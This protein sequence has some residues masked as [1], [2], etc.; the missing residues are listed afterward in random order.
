MPVRPSYVELRIHG[1]SGTTPEDML[2]TTQVEDVAGDELVRFVRAAEPTAGELPGDGV[3]EAVSWGRLTSGLAA[4]AAWVVM[5]PFALVNL[6]MWT[7]RSFTETSSRPRAARVRAAASRGCVRL[8]G[9]TVTVVVTLAA[10]LLA[11]D[12]VGWQCGRVACAVVSDRLAFAEAWSRGARVAVASAVPVVVLAAIAWLSHRVS[13]RY[14]AA[15]PSDLTE[16]GAASGTRRTAGAGAASGTGAQPE[17]TQ[18]LVEQQPNLFSPLMWHAEPMVQRLRCVHLSVG[19]ASVGVLLVWA[20][21]E[22]VGAAVLRGGVD[23]ALWW[24]ATAC[25]ALVIVA[26]GLLVALPTG[27]VAWTERPLQ[28]QGAVATALQLL[29]LAGVGLAAASFARTVDGLAEDVTGPIPGLGGVLAVVVW[30]Q[31][32]VL[33]ALG[34]VQLSWSRIDHAVDR[35]A[36]WVLDRLVPRPVRRLLTARSTVR[37][38]V[39]TAR[40]LRALSRDRARTRSADEAEPQRGRA[41]AR[42]DSDDPQRGRGAPLPGRDAARS[43]GPRRTL[44]ARLRDGVAG[45]KAR[46]QRRAER[47]AAPPT[48]RP[49]SQLPAFL[50]LAPWVVAASGVLLAYVYAAGLTLRIGALLTPTDPDEGALAVPALLTWASGGFA[51]VVALAVLTGAVAFVLVSRVPAR[52][53]VGVVETFVHH[54]ALRPADRPT[55]YSDW[56]DDFRIRRIVRARRLQRLV[57]ARWIL[58]GLGCASILGVLIAVAALTSS[59]EPLASLM[60]GRPAPG[61][62]VA[63]APDAAT[64]DVT[65]PVAVGSGLS[66]AGSWALTALAVGVIG[67]VVAGWRSPAVRRRVGVAWDVLSF[68]PRGGHPF[69]PPSYTERAVPQIVARTR[70]LAREPATRPRV[71]LSGHSQGSVL[72]AAVVAQ[73]RTL[74]AAEGFP[75]GQGTLARVALLT[76]GSPLG[77]L[78][79]PLFPQYFS[80]AELV[81]ATAP[82]GDATGARAARHEV[83]GPEQ[84]RVL[85]AALGG[86]WLNLWRDTDPIG[87]SLASALHGHDIECR[88]P[89]DYLLDEERAAYPP[90]HGHSDYPGACEYVRAREHLVGVPASGGG[91]D[92]CTRCVPTGGGATTTAAAGAGEATGEDEA[93]GSAAATSGTTTVAPATANGTVAPAPAGATGATTTAPPADATGATAAAVS[94]GTTG[95]TTAPPAEATGAP[96]STT[97]PG[98]FPVPAP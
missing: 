87:S 11:M 32:A 88:D 8:L 33:L 51:V 28:H 93:A 48:P 61:P 84:L 77:R 66:A 38:P 7:S 96:V 29:A 76:H 97:P 82:A 49:E 94:A 92:G 13:L 68:W 71:L 57:Q 78:Y 10:A 59:I 90:V 43:D 55:A 75:A 27:W 63:V 26:G 53:V 52:D 42:P 36:G 16:P 67:L 60:R 23:S 65:W 31:V 64:S 17:P 83:G 14:E 69:A 79:Q 47:R 89:L 2:G 86:R 37:H 3:L 12:L 46:A 15:S 30:V 34:G 74:D 1:V 73:L 41:D 45:R 91:P 72:A 18:P 50:G 54:H 4:Q 80:G 85:D 39:R 21:R 56:R 25:L 70:F 81:P 58:D 22:Q 9:L 19:W 24:A 44:A 6:A 62:E 35:A 98:T 5:L 20:V 95:A 40:A